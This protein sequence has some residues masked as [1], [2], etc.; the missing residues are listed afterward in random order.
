VE[1]VSKMLKID[2]KL[3]TSG[4]KEEKKEEV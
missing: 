2:R 1:E 3:Y 4:G